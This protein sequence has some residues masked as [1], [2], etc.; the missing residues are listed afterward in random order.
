MK[1]PSAILASVYTSV[2][3]MTM[4]GANSSTSSKTSLASL[5]YRLKSLEPAGIDID[6]THW[7]DAPDAIQDIVLELIDFRAT[8]PPGTALVS[9]LCSYPVT[10]KIDLLTIVC[11]RLG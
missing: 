3:V 7:M 2:Q 1:M 9:T 11:R 8:V 5:G 4:S 10:G 6:G